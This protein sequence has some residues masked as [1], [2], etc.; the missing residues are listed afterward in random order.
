[1][2]PFEAPNIKIEMSDGKAAGVAIGAL[3]AHGKAD[4][5]P[6]AHQLDI[7]A[8]ILRD[9]VPVVSISGPGLPAIRGKNLEWAA[10]EL[11]CA[12][13]II[14]RLASVVPR[15]ARDMV[16]AEVVE[17][18]V[19]A[20]TMIRD[21]A[22]TNWSEDPLVGPKDHGWCA[23]VAMSALASVEELTS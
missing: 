11:E 8:Q 10:G 7:R 3:V 17:R 6:A 14:R 1:M 9:I 4:V 20:L 22:G 5:E 23:G 15:T 12:A 13:Q 21:E 19:D 2:P 16:N 18:L